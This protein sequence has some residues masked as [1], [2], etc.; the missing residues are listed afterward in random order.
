VTTAVNNN[1]G[2]GSVRRKVVENKIEQRRPQVDKQQKRE[3]QQ[4][5]AIKHDPLTTTVGVTVADAITPTKGITIAT[6]SSQ[7]RNSDK[8]PTAVQEHNVTSQYNEVIENCL[9]VKVEDLRAELKTLQTEYE[10]TTKALRED[11]ENTRAKHDA[12]VERLRAA[13]NKIATLKQKRAD[14]ETA[15]KTLNLESENLRLTGILNE[16]S[17]QKSIFEKMKVEHEAAILSLRKENELLHENHEIA[18]NKQ[19]INNETAI[20]ELRNL[21]IDLSDK[22]QLEMKD[23]C[24]NYESRLKQICEEN[25]NLLTE[26]SKTIEMLRHE[27]QSMMVS[28]AERL[29]K[30]YTAA[31]KCLLVQHQTEIEQLKLQL[32]QLQQ[33]SVSI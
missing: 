17:N 29:S 8:K 33:N 1:S 9:R 4:Q 20:Q 32:V 16:Q 14:Q 28:E 2:S 21:A 25:R 19:R 23:L 27:H 6:K 7:S 11:N 13:E 22:Y 5:Q 18:L 26:H 31:T 24:A 3:K 15:M 30:E 10:T 12:V